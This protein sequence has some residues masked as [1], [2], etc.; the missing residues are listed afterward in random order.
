MD[1]D[2]LNKIGQIDA[3]VF[4][5]ME[6]MY[7]KCPYCGEEH[8][9]DDYVAVKKKIDSKQISTKISGKIV[10]RTYLDSYVNIRVCSKCS[11]KKK[12]VEGIVNVICFII[13]PVIFSINYFV[14]K[15]ASI[16][17]FLG[18]ILALYFIM[19]IIEAIVRLFIENS[20]FNIDIE[21]AFNDNAI[22][23]SV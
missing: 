17:N 10:T 14:K 18:T 3:P 12:L 16:Q 1:K 4:S 2:L 20:F 15:D 5:H 6:G 8:R 11:K 7:Y 13:I 22:I 23:E 21:K 19:L 9:I